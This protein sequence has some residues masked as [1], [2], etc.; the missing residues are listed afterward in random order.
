MVERAMHTLSRP[1]LDPQAVQTAEQLLTEQAPIP[2]PAKLHKFARTVVAAADP[3][4]PEP[5]DDQL[6]Q[7]RRYLELTQRSA[8]TTTPTSRR[9]AGAAGST[10]TGY[11]NGSHPAGSTKINN[12]ASDACIPNGDSTAIDGDEHP[13]QH[14]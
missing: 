10:P 12:P 11:P 1:N 9:K 8:D 14:D 6:Q 2:S 3:D 7:D 4:G 13:Q 5:I